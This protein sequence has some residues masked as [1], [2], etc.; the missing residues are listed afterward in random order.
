M[1]LDLLKKRRS[2]RKYEDRPVEQEK[3]DQLL[4]AALRSPSSRGRNPWEFVVTTDPELRR[5]IALAKEH[6]SA[7]LAEAPLVVAVVADPEKCD[8]WIEDCSIASIIL[9]LTAESLGLSSCWVQIR[10]RD[11][12][13]EISAEKY[14]KQLLDL[15]ER[16]VVEA[17]IGIGYPGESKPGHPVESLDWDKIHISRFTQG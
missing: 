7:F 15:P 5:R 14:L 4:E 6:G 9:Q 13:D 2:I 1:V 8:V 10:R 12:N 16:F 11:H 17:V 3:I